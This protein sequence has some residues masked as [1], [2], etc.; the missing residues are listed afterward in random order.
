MKISSKRVL[1]ATVAGLAVAGG[2]AAIA[3]SQNDSSSSFFDSLAQ[4]LGISSEELED[5]AR[6]A[7]LDQVDA[8]VEEG[9]ITEEQAEELRSRIESGELPPFFGPGPFGGLHEKAHAFGDHFSAAADYLGVTVEELRERLEAGQSL[10]DVAEAEGKSVDGLKQAIL[11]EA[12][13]SLNEAVE[14]ETLTR[15]Q[16]D[17]AL[18]R[19]ETRVNDLVEGTFEG[20]RGHHFFGGPPGGGRPDDGPSFWGA[21]A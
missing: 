17:A 8:A 1:A 7:A 9:R 20:R 6:A 15:E 19:L 16:A 11:D 10:A 4:H 5:A 2:G 18:E 12:R 3:G 14:E 13:K 21:A